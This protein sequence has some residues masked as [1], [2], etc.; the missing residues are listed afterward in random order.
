MKF[1]GLFGHSRGT[2]HIDFGGNPG[3]DPDPGKG[4]SS[5][6]WQW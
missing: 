1:Y 5:W 4:I 2:N 3:L 6:Y